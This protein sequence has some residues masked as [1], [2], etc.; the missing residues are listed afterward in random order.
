VQGVGERDGEIG[1]E[2]GGREGGREG[3]KW[4]RTKNLLDHEPLI[5][6]DTF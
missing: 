4:G 2:E 1:R 3:G 6:T 5:L